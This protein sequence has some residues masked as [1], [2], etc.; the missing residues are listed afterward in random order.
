M[1]HAR[2][3]R[4]SE[5]QAHATANRP[6]IHPDQH[7]V[8]RLRRPTGGAPISP[9]LSTTS[10]LQPVPPSLSSGRDAQS[11]PGAAGTG[12]L[13][14]GAGGT[15]GGTSELSGNPPA[16]LLSRM[17]ADTQGPPPFLISIYKRAAQRYHVPWPVLAAINSIESDYGRNLNVSSAGAVGWMQFMPGTWRE[18]G[19]DANHDGKANP[20]DPTRRD[21]RRRALPACQRGAS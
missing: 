4:Q 8:L 19:V 16:G 21:L 6:A 18:Y 12:G 10:Q 15:S 2:P 3:E 17:F 7:H 5:G 14:A 9:P 1:E 20:Y 13:F 11:E